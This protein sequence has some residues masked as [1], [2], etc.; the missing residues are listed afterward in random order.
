MIQKNFVLAYVLL[1]GLPL[2]GIFT[3]LNAGRGLV[4]P[5][6]VSGEWDLT[7][8]AGATAD[9]CFG[10]LTAAPRQTVA[11]TQSGA[12]VSLSFDQPQKIA[13]TG[14]FEGKR[15]T[16]IGSLKSPAGACTEGAALHWTAMVM[17]TPAQRTLDGQFFFDA[18][19]SCIPVAFR[20]ARRIPLRKP[21]Q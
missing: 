2:L 10:P 13:L 4:P 11:I 3:V 16:G 17:G 6:A 21:G 18:C 19:K 7:V 15:L 5:P 9:N 12:G 20:A 8:D 14:T 1:V